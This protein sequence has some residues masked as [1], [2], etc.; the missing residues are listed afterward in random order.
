LHTNHHAERADRQSAGAARLQHKAQ[1]I[2]F[3]RCARGDH[4]GQRAELKS[5]S[6]ERPFKQHPSCLNR[7]V[8]NHLEINNWLPLFIL[9]R[10][11][12]TLLQKSSTSSVFQISKRT[13]R[14]N[15]GKSQSQVLADI[16]STFCIFRL[17][18]WHHKKC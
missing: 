11:V 5:L 18:W 13:N 14:Y 1:R 4:D 8:S 16:V 6:R 9:A 17:G 2:K 3:V 12:F 10:G 15:I 7:A